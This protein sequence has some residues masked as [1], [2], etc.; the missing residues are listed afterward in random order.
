M[1]QQVNY[2]VKNFN[3]KIFKYNMEGQKI[4]L[5]YGNGILI[6]LLTLPCLHQCCSF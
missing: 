3:L 5:K 1:K 6:L 2:S 4:P